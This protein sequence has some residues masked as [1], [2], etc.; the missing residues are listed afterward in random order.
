M[1]AE[2]P[3]AMIARCAAKMPT[4]YGFRDKMRPE[5][6]RAILAEAHVL[7]LLNVLDGA[8]HALRSYQYG[9]VAPDLAEGIAD[10]CDRV[11]ALAK[12]DGG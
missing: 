4:G 2:L 8:S 6:V 10:A 1:V 12:G 5:I 9:N 3:A 7:E 11:V